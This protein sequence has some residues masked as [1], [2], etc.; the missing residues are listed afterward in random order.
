MGIMM[1]I[2]LGVGVCAICAVLQMLF[3]ARGLRWL[4]AAPLK[5][6]SRFTT[7]A[8]L[9]VLLAHIIQ[10]A[11]WTAIFLPNGGFETFEETLYFSIATYTTLGYGDALIVPELRVLGSMAAVA[12]LI[13]FGISTAFLYAVLSELVRPAP[14]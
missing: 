1:Q 12:G 7:S 3:V 2:T 5:R 10:I 11:I 6:R 14:H 9:A 8:I 13:S 4:D